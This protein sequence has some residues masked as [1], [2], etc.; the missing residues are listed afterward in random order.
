MAQLSNPVQPF[1]EVNVARSGN[2][3]SVK[4]IV[5]M[6]PNVEK[7]S[8]GLALDASAS[9]SQLYGLKTGPFMVKPN[10]VEPV[11]RIMS[12]LLAN[13]SGDGKC[14]LLY[15]AC[16][17]DG[18]QV[19]YLGNFTA[20]ELSTLSLGGP[21]KSAWGRQ[22]K[23]LP[24]VRY[25]AEHAFKTAK[26][27]IGVI[28]TDGIVD[29]LDEVINYSLELGKQMAAG[30]RQFLK[31]VLIGL[32]E[33][34]DKAQMEKLDDMFDGTNLKTPEG[35][36]IDIWDHKLAADMKR[37]EE[38]FPEIFDEDTIICETGRVL[39]NTGNVVKEYKDGVPALLKF[40]LPSGSTSFTLEYPGGHIRQDISE[41]LG[42]L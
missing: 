26:W 7:A 4:A 6:K 2:E 39:D 18:S 36:E 24:P 29:D 38:I 40:N 20:A 23:L 19:E 9:M 5:L 35:R 33:A 37:L 13:F 1:G 30:Q 41:V 27:A 14:H 10:S 22:T 15:W 32:G 25:F 34:V 11:A 16:S 8:V 21:L 42:R 31:L 12:T 28:V 17:A 3:L